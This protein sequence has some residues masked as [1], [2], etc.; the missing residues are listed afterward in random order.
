MLE[1]KRLFAAG[2]TLAWLAALGCYDFEGAFQDCVASGQCKPEGCKKEWA[3]AP[4]EFSHDNN[5]DGIDGDPNNAFFVDPVLGK[6]TNPGTPQAP[7]QTLSHAVTAAAA[8]GKALYLAQGNY[9]EPAF[10]LDKPVSLHGGYSGLDGGWARDGG[11]TTRIGGGS[12]GLTVSGLGEDAGVVLE[13]LHIESVQPPDAGAPSIGLRVMGSG[14][15]RLRY[16]QVVAGPG[17]PGTAGTSPVINP[18][19]GADGGDGESSRRTD[20]RMRADGGTPGL[21]SCGDVAARSGG[22]GGLGGQLAN[23]ATDGLAGERATD[24]GTAGTPQDLPDCT[25]TVEC[26]CTGRPG[27]NGQQGLDGAP[28]DDG[29][30]GNALGQLT[31]D[32]W[33]A[34]TG[35]TGGPGQPGEGGGGGGG[36]GYC[37]MG[38]YSS[39]EG[40][41]GGGGGSGGCPGTGASGGGGG[42]ASIAVLLIQGHVSL[43]NSTLTTTGGGQGGAGGT[44]GNGSPGG[45]GGTGGTGYTDRVTFT[46][47]H[48]TSIGGTGGNGGN[49]GNG[50]RGGHGGNGG[51]GPSV[52]VWCDPDSTVA[53]KGSTFNL[54][55]SG[56]PG[57]GLGLKTPAVPPAQYQECTPLR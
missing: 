44:G 52:G 33:V 36:G 3:D 42:G 57:T 39:A 5:C 27:T 29:P 20:P 14:G 30:A 21:S 2:L 43:E 22:R 7:F 37:R 11:Y 9:D 32:S 53:E 8:A 51:G 40:A 17:A 49:G 48:A 56:Q 34:S 16:V 6:N 38:T 46:T 31:N 4:D 19:G 41:G 24:G 1:T 15:V 50:G 47:P 45:K 26:V 35:S 23:P 54:G 55:P 25:G 10:R 13:R 18:R 28:G 12:I